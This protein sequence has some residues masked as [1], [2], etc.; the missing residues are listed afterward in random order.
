EAVGGETQLAEL[1]GG[2][3]AHHADGEGKVHA[4][5]S[6]RCGARWERDEVGISEP[7]TKLVRML[8]KQHPPVE[9]RSEWQRRR[10]LRNTGVY[11]GAS[12]GMTRSGNGAR[13]SSP[14]RRRPTSS[15]Q[16]PPWHRAGGSP[17]TS[18]LT[19]RWRMT[20]PGGFRSTRPSRI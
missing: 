10:R 20:R 19:S 8:A 3:T 13:S 7:V 12:H 9:G 4:S 16:K 18:I 2:Q 1:V 14:R 15:R 11:A 17:R 6:G 5:R